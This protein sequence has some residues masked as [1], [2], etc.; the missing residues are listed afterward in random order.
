MIQLQPI[1]IHCRYQNQ[2]MKEISFPEAPP[3][4]TLSVPLRETAQ[5]G[6]S[7]VVIAPPQSVPSFVVTL[8]FWAHSAQPP[9]LLLPS[10]NLNYY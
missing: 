4:L 10:M 2:M 8:T 5:L 3:L 9:S 7:N 1:Q 6:Q